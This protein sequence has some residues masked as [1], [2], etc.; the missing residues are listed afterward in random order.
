[1]DTPQ[2][3]PDVLFVDDLARLL[4]TSPRTIYRLIKAGAFPFAPLPYALDRKLRWSRA[5]VMATL[6]AGVTV[7]PSPR[8]VA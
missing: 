7:R 3:W 6:A 2:A 1:M 5:V 4:R 8:R